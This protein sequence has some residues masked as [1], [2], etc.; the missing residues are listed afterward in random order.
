M[1]YL[2]AGEIGEATTVICPKAT[3]GVEP[4]QGHRIVRNTPVMRGMLEDFEIPYSVFLFE[5]GVLRGGGGKGVLQALEDDPQEHLSFDVPALF[6]ALIEFASPILLDQGELVNVNWDAESQ[7]ADLCMKFGGTLRG[8]EFRV[9]EFDRC[10]LDS[11]V[12]GSAAPNLSFRDLARVVQVEQA[13]FKAEGF[14]EK[15]DIVHVDPELKTPITSIHT[16]RGFVTVF[17]QAKASLEEVQDSL[18]RFLE[19]PKISDMNRSPIAKPHMF[20]VCHKNSPQ[21]CPVT[22]SEVSQTEWIVEGLVGGV[23]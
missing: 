16:H 2:I 21:F 8:K 14:F 5:S 7:E 22:V 13:Q 11:T 1:N 18:E 19:D 9:F 17:A 3:V 12:E 23:G 20:S 4:L 15:Y 6:D 10:V